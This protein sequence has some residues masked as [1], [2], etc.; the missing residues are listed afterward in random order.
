M[1]EEQ[2][3]A[4]LVAEARRMNAIGLNQ[5]TSGNLS[6]RLGE[7]MLITPSAMPYDVMRPADIARMPLHENGRWSGPRAPSTEWRLHLDILRERPEIGAVVHTHAVH[8]T[9]LSMLRRPIPPCHYMIAAFGGGDVRCADYATFGTEALS[10]HALDALRDRTAC[11]LASHGMVALGTSLAQAMW[12]AVELETLAR[13]YLLAAS[14]GAPSL[15]T[16]AEIDE[17]LAKFATYI[18]A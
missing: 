10:A 13:Q 2:A 1:T 4:A 3:R 17:T 9:A 11:L 18:S 16:P 15:L 7:A 6:V 14:L 12:R 8:A 5:G